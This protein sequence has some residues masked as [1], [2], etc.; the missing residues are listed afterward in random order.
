MS[1]SFQSMNSDPPHSGTDTAVDLEAGLTHSPLPT[2]A[3]F[4]LGLAKRGSLGEGGW[5]RL[6]I[7]EFTRPPGKVPRVPQLHVDGTPILCIW[8]WGGRSEL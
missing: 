5:K 7:P 4:C 1:P 6:R 8:R 2:N 3:P